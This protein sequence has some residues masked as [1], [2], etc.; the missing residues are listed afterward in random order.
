MPPAAAG[1]APARRPNLAFLAGVAL[2][3]VTAVL[4]VVAV[5]SVIDVLARSP[6]D[7]IYLL[8][9]TPPPAL[10]GPSAAP[11]DAYTLHVAVESLDEAKELATLRVYA[12]RACP[13]TCPALGI[14]L[15]ALGG[16]A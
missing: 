14:S 9:D 11:V 15:L 2:L 3:A 8:S 10:G 1:K 12:V 4:I 5:A 7:A 13:T 16:P 6:R